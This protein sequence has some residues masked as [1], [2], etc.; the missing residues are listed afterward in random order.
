[1]HKNVHCS[2]M[3]NPEDVL[4]NKYLRK[5]NVLP[6]TQQWLNNMRGYGFFFC[7]SFPACS[8]PVARH[9][10]SLCCHRSWCVSKPELLTDYLTASHL[11]KACAPK[12]VHPSVPMG[13]TGR[14]KHAFESCEMMAAWERHVRTVQ[15]YGR[16]W[17]AKRNGYLVGPCSQNPKS[18]RA[19]NWQDSCAQQGK[20]DVIQDEGSRW[21]G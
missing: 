4:N 18:Q 15:A 12:T 14:E 5:D 9:H 1:M 17:S 2:V 19:Q 8:S 13:A 3:Y 11:L 21:L 6:I 20:E 7:V 16:E 10:T